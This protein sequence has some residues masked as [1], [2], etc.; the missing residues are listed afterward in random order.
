MEI[1]SCIRCLNHYA[2]GKRVQSLTLSGTC[3]VIIFLLMLFFDIDDIYSP[4]VLPL[5][6]AEEFLEV[7]IVV[8]G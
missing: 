5:Y 4:F 6:V 7:R 3:R 2:I 1:P 8:Q